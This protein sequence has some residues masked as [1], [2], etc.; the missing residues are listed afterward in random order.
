MSF[1]YPQF[2]W[3][4]LAL[5]IP[6]IIHLFNF[7]RTRRVYFSNTAFLK[8]VKEATTSK[9]KVKHWLILLSRL[10]FIACLVFTFAQPFFPGNAGD[11]ATA[12]K[13]VYLYLDN[14]LSMS[15]EL[16]SGVRSVDQAVGVIDEITRQYPR[17]TRYKLLTNAFGSFSRV[18]KNEEELSD[19]TR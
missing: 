8:N 12:N 16:A 4:L 14:S 5:G 10:L 11:E 2:L 19:L 15:S 7:R 6:I 17:N 3:G 1:V 9:L 18:P 13:L